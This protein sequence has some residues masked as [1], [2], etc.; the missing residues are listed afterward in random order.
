[1]PSAVAAPRGVQRNLIAHLDVQF[2]GEPRADCD[3]RNLIETVDRAK[4]DIVGD[5]LELLQ[6]GSRKPR[7]SAP[8]E[9]EGVETITCPSTRKREF[10]AGHGADPRRHVVVIGEVREA[11]HDDMAVQ[12]EHLVEQLL[13]EAVHHRHHNDERGDA[14]HDADEGE[15]GDDRDE[16]PCGAPAGSAAPP[17]TRRGRRLAFPSLRSCGY[18]ASF[19]RGLNQAI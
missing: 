14:K 3:A 15:T 17:S 1:M 16:A 4:A 9:V 8:L 18:L 12:S 6:V 11:M 5:G 19:A 10:D 2:V 7:T 13:A